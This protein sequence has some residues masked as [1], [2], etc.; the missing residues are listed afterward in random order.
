M[1]R[2]IPTPKPIPPAIQFESS[3]AQRVPNLKISVTS[4][5]KATPKQNATAPFIVLTAPRHTFMTAGKRGKK[6]KY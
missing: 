5:N 4:L 6:E 2:R 1:N 3:C